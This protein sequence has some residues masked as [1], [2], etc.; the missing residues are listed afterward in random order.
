MNSIV[1][2]IYMTD[3][4]NQGSSVAAEHFTAAMAQAATGVSIVTTDGTGG[5][6]GMTVS[7]FASVSAEPPLVLVC[8]NR[9]SPLVDAVGDNRIFCVNLLSTKQR[10]LSDKFSGRPHSGEP[11]A[12]E[13]HLWG[14][15]IT[16][17]PVLLGALAQ[18]DCTLESAHDAG[19]H[20]VLIGRVH[21]AASTE[22]TPLVYNAREYQQLTQL[23]DFDT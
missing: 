16:G 6:F 21:H 2:N 13:D 4:G 7:A 22:N 20:R 15:E 19:S 1:R 10:A 14:N 17:A 8:I 23:Q 12:F 3:K 9:R 18:F 5:R 11:Y